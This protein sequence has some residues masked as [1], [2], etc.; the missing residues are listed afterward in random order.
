MSTTREALALHAAGRTTEALVL[1]FDAVGGASQPSASSDMRQLLAQLLEGVS[2]DSGNAVIHRVLLELLADPAIDAQQVARAALGLIMASPEFTA[3][4]GW[5]EVP[6][7]TIDESMLAPALEAFVNLPLVR[8]LFPRVVLSN[9][10]AERVA[11]FARRALLAS[12]MG[13]SPA[14]AWHWDGVTLLAQSAFNGEYAWLE[15]HDEREFIDAAAA[16]L[17]SWLAAR[18]RATSEAIADAPGPLLLLHAMYRRLTSLP[19]WEQLADVSDATWGSSRAPVAGA[20]ERHVRERLDE[21][22]RAERMPVLLPSVAAE[23]DDASARVRAMYEAH[24][25]PRWSTIGTPRVTGVAQFIRELAGRDGPPESLRLLVAGCGT[26]RQAA[27]TARSFPDARVLALDLSR[28]SLGYAA[29]M[30][31]KLV[32]DTV[33]F[34]QGDL[35]DLHALEEQFAIVFCSGVLHHMQDPLAGWTQLVHRLHPQGVMKI[36]LYS[37]AA[38]QPVHAARALLD[39]HTFAGTDSDVRHCRELLLALPADHPAHGVTDSTDFYS[40][41]GCRDLVMHVQERTYTIPQIA[42]ALESLRLRFLGFQV[43]VTVQHAFAR[44]HPARDAAR[45]LN[46][47]AQFEAK[48][49]TT[50]WGMYQ[51]FVEKS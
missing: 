51:F 14:L 31:E 27:H 29:R 19:D 42:E 18:A 47:W 20:I 24:P 9:P 41:S 3:L 10:R 33:D 16:S 28:A 11:T 43:P 5:C 2:L 32:I 21:R 23:H 45:D 46:A 7:D 37:D 50:F 15:R 25:Y 49:P 13:E 1:L 44:E 12:I 26:G 38:R 30:T 22:R 8:G 35:L 6:D 17:E 4:E 40:L 48:H 36:A 39:A 34:M